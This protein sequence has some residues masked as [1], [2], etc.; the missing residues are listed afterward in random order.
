[1]N[2]S[3]A[4][5]QPIPHSP[6]RTNP[7]TGPGA[8]TSPRAAPGG[9]PQPR[10]GRRAARRTRSTHPSSPTLSLPQHRPQHRAGRWQPAPA[11]APLSSS[12]PP[13]YLQ[14]ASRQHRH[15]QFFSQAQGREP[16]QAASRQ[17]GR[18]AGRGAGLPGQGQGRE[19][20]A[21]GPA[22]CGMLAVTNKADK[23]FFVLLPPQGVS[24]TL[25]KEKQTG[26]HMHGF[27]SS[28]FLLLVVSLGV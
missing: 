14:A 20:S 11:P 25:E 5:P 19:P 23:A 18:P 1:M 8:E 26:T 27:L 16:K 3:P 6:S 12:Q 21:P 15:T 22:Q 7:R 13:S 17:H 4:N 2:G 10:L 9:S 28:F 24:L